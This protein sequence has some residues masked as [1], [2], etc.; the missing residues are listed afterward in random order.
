MATEYVIDFTEPEPLEIVEGIEN[1]YE[2]PFLWRV[3]LLLMSKFVPEMVEAT[4]WKVRAA[5][6]ERAAIV[7]EHHVVIDTLGELTRL[8][9]GDILTHVNRMGPGAFTPDTYQR[10]TPRPGISRDYQEQL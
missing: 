6:L 1:P 2:E 3:E 5:A 9:E 10:Q 8:I 7:K 4:I